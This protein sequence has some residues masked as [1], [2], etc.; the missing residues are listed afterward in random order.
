M[1]GQRQ[2]KPLDRSSREW[3]HQHRLFCHVAQGTAK[4][5]G[6]ADPWE[7]SPQWCDGWAWGFQNPSINNEWVSK[8]DRNRENQTASHDER[9][10]TDDKGNG[11]HAQWES[12][13]PMRA[14]AGK[15][16]LDLDVRCNQAICGDPARRELACGR[17]KTA[18]PD[19]EEAG[20]VERLWWGNGKT[21]KKVG[22]KV[23]NGKQGREEAEC[24]C[25]QLHATEDT[26]ATAEVTKTCWAWVVGILHSAGNA[27]SLVHPV[28]IWQKA[29]RRLLAWTSTA[30]WL[31]WCD[32]EPFSCT[33]ASC[34]P[35]CHKCGGADQGMTRCK[36]SDSYHSPPTWENTDCRSICRCR[37]K[38]PE[39]P[40]VSL[41]GTKVQSWQK[42]SPWLLQ[43]VCLLQ[44]HASWNAWE[45][46]NGDHH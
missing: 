34:K 32:D 7:A 12:A 22:K 5:N 15:M 11:A 27:S 40:L 26:T 29:S 2:L 37:H 24:A 20:E 6:S 8:D 16:A 21:R 36:H 9:T 46:Q 4:W 44:H 39:H 33:I 3:R 30:A 42:V 41:V 38:D 45:S 19:G 31:G 1:P 13:A 25:Q 14:D 35:P 17:K 28:A 18:P 43:Q 23:E 10:G